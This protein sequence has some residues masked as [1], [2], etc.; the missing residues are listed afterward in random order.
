MVSN[1]FQLIG[2][3]MN[4]TNWLCNY[5]IIRVHF[6]KMDTYDAE[7]KIKN[8]FRMNSVGAASFICIN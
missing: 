6:K 1:V 5:R 7:L 3:I 4:V 2:I 8:D